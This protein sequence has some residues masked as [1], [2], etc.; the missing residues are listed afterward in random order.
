ML[1]L[2]GIETRTRDAGIVDVGWSG[3]IGVCAVYLAF[4]SDGWLP[5]RCLVG[6]LAALWSVRLAGYL[7]SDRIAR[8]DEDFR[9][10]ALRE[11][12]GGRAHLYFLLTF[13]VQALL[14]VP[15]VG[16]L[17]VLMTYGR[18]AFS[19]WE[20]T[21]ALLAVAAV[22]GEATA[23][24]QMARFRN[25]PANRGAVCRAGLWRYSRHPNYFFE[26]LHWASYSVMAIGVPGGWWTLT[27]SL[28][29]L[30]PLFL[31]TGIPATEAQALRTRGE[32]YR[33]YQRST[34]MFVPWFP[35]RP[36]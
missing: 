27:G 17:V 28:G 29:I 24:R 6:S 23:D 13:L 9:Y 8:R 15:F 21:G 4:V 26:W 12:W 14:V 5:R 34:S 32:A 7:L 20:L 19:G 10:R 33:A 16:P 1:C 2:W 30:V 18:E 35:N 25:A 22:V 3:S 11:K 31:L 36:R